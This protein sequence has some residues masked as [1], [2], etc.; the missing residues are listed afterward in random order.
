MRVTARDALANIKRP[1]VVL[2]ATTPLVTPEGLVKLVASLYL[3]AGISI[4][5]FTPRS[6]RLR[7][8]DHF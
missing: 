4:M 5:A 8:A 2:S 6:K 3:R 7:P 1:V